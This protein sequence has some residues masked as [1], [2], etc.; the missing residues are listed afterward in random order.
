M[1][2]VMYVQTNLGFLSDVHMLL[3]LTCILLFMENMQSLLKFA[4]RGD[5]FVS[6]FIVAIKVCQGQL[7]NF[8]L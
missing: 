1:H 2:G 8:V 6:N 4:Q 3:R 5:I 7:Y